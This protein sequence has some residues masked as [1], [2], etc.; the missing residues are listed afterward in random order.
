MRTDDHWPLVFENGHRLRKLREAQ[1]LSQSAL[2]AAID[3]HPG[4]VSDLEN[5]KRVMTPSVALRMSAALTQEDPRD[6]IAQAL[7]IIL[8]REGLAYRVTRGG[9]RY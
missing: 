2:A 6:L 4:F 7:T 9:L 8:K 3:M 5:G 1:E